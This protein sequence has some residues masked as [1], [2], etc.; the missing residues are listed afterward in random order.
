MADEEKTFTKPTLASIQLPEEDADKPAEINLTITEGD[1]GV[2]AN[3]PENKETDEAKKAA[4]ANAAKEKEAADKKA[5]DD[6]T[7]TPE[8]V[9]AESDAA[10]KAEEDKKLTPFHEHPDWKKMEERLKTAED[11][12]TQAEIAAAEAK[13]KADA[14]LESKGTTTTEKQ[15][16]AK[17]ATER[18]KE[19][20][21]NGWEPKDRMEEFER[22]NTYLAEELEAKEKAKTD[23]A[24]TQ[25][26]EI[27][28]RREAILN[29]INT[30]TTELGLSETESEAVI[31][32]TNELI[33]QKVITP[34]PDAIGAAIKYVH[35]S[36]KAAG[37]LAPAKTA[38]QIEAERVATEKAA[39]DKKAAEDAAARQ[40]NTNSKISRGSNGSNTATIPEKKPLAKLRRSLDDIVLENGK[41]LG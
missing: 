38:E 2:S 1:E 10:A 31:K 5:A 20:A 23:E 6:A 7:K 4:D 41:T 34:S 17:S 32:R 11:R 8:Q 12:A 29:S 22:Y 9:K 30:T 35:S 16:A 24:T 39:A 15:S 21:K 37:E 25:T 18:M 3:D 19:D 13:G 33:Q 40:K 28:K 27:T 26:T 14:L 36:M